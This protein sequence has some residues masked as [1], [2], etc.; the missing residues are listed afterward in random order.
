[1][2]VFVRKIEAP[3]LDYYLRDKI[4]ELYNEFGKERV[5]KEV[6]VDFHPATGKIEGLNMAV[7]YNMEAEL[8]TVPDR[9]HLLQKPLGQL[10][11][12]EREDFIVRPP[13]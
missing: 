2:E 4:K 7:L 3:S 12:A 10:T 5:D 11:D 9:A 1:M 6:F 8:H 13:Y